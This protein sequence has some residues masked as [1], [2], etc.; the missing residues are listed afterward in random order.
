M[1]MKSTDTTKSADARGNHFQHLRELHDDE[2]DSVSG[3]DIYLQH[4]RGSGNRLFAL[5]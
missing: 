2:L 3:G 5:D 1:I 4:P